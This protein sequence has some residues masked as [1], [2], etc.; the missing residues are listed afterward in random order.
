MTTTTKFD[1]SRPC[2]AEAVRTGALDPRLLVDVPAS[3][4]WKAE[5]T[6]IMAKKIADNLAPDDV[7][8]PI[9]EIQRPENLSSLC[10]CHKQAKSPSV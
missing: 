1:G 5:V 7:P 9:A 4:T 10:R 3:A 8:I 2:F 6:R